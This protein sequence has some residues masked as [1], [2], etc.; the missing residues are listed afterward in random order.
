MGRTSQRLLGNTG[1]GGRTSARFTSA[2][3]PTNVEPEKK[4]AGGFIKNIGSSAWDVAK[5]VGN[6][7][8]H[9]IES[10]KNIGGTVVGAVQLAIPGEQSQEV[11]AKAVGTF[12]KDRYGSMSKAKETAYKDPVGFLLDASTV[13]TGG[14]AAIAKAG[15]ISKAA[16]VG[17]LTKAVGAAKAAGLSTAL[18]SKTRVLSNIEKAAVAGA[19]KLT[20]AEKAAEISRASRA[21]ELGGLAKAGSYMSQAGALVDPFQIAGKIAAPVVSRVGERAKELAG[22]ISEKL[23][24]TELKLNPSDVTKIAKPNVAGVTPANWLKEKGIFGSREQ[25]I[26]K[27]ETLGKES[28][29]QVDAALA[30]IPTKY[31]FQT[32]PR[33]EN[34]LQMLKQNFDGIAGAEADAAKVEALIAKGMKGDLNLAD[35]NEVKRMGDKFSPAYNRAGDI[36]STVQGQGLANMRGE[37]KVFIEKEAEKAG[38][39]NIK[40]LNKDTQVSHEIANA[41]KKKMLGQNAN[42]VL[43]LTDFLMGGAGGATAGLPGIFVAMI[44]KKIIEHPAFKMFFA[45]RLAKLSTTELNALEK[46]AKIGK[47]TEE[48]TTILQTIAEEIKRHPAFVAEVGRI[49]QGITAPPGL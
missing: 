4:S 41:A 37:I 12:F 38:I 44:G 10:A 2:Q 35:I 5:G 21:G 30:G 29:A 15:T 3:A 45:K 14:G 8:I 6:L 31:S 11:K 26:D 23:I 25:I 13:L 22:N 33:V 39:A 16:Q 1:T 36:K 9:P 18:G 47:P 48:A 40:Q 46:A 32:A 24:S 28:K 43:G 20:R 19:G 27:V 17:K 34:V 49:N 42:R 7:A